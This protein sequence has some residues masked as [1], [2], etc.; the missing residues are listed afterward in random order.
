MGV[1][2]GSSTFCT[3]V[4]ETWHD[5][6]MDVWYKWRWH[7]PHPCLLKFMCQWRWCLVRLYFSK[8]VLMVLVVGLPKPTKVDA[9]QVINQRIL[10]PR[11]NTNKQILLLK[12][13]KCQRTEQK[14]SKKIVL[15][16]EAIQCTR[17]CFEIILDLFTQLMTLQYFQLCLSYGMVLV[18]LPIFS[19]A[20]CS[21]RTCFL[22]WIRPPS[23]STQSSTL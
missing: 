7:G 19:I 8:S 5:C 4:T 23:P 10:V 1:A 14:L 6:M 13:S 18:P 15:N 3:W 2:Y 9:Q 17:M 16:R 11:E 20:R 21:R 22:S 12:S